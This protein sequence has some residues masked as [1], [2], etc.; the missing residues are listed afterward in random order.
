MDLLPRLLVFFIYFSPFKVGP[1]EANKTRTVSSLVPP[2]GPHQFSFFPPNGFPPQ[3][4]HLEEI[5]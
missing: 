2:L 4:V 3:S 5:G 1:K